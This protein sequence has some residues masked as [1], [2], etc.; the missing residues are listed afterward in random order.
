MKWLRALLAV[1]LLLLPAA[2][3][4]ALDTPPMPIPSWCLRDIL[5]DPVT[6]AEGTVSQHETGFT[7]F[8][9]TVRAEGCPMTRASAVYRTVHLDTEDNDLIL[10]SGTLTWDP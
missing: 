10:A 8:A 7:W 4:A 1:P 5:I 3:A 6:K 2:P 9:F